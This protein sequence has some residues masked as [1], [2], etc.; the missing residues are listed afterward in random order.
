VHVAV[1]QDGVAHLRKINVSRDLGT[2][3]QVK[4]GVKQ[5]ESVIL[6]PSVNLAEG[7]KV[8][9]AAPDRNT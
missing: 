7:S 9:I 1:V 5:G 3:V 2:E 6:N 4:D 8:Q